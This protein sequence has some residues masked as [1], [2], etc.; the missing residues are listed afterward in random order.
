MVCLRLPVYIVSVALEKKVQSLYS[1]GVRQLIVQCKLVYL[2]LSLPGGK[3]YT[4]FG[5]IEGD[6]R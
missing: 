5:G 4:V 3:V 6:D 2:I 1:I